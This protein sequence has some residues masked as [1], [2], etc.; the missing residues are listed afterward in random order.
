M[1]SIIELEE[2]PIGELWKPFFTGAKNIVD[3]AIARA[4]AEEAADE[5]KIVN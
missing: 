3:K 1:A 4:K 2:A 5:V